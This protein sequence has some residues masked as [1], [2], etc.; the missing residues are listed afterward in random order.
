M[1][2]NLYLSIL[3]IE[4]KDTPYLDTLDFLIKF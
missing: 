1:K 4:M 3:Q 2:N